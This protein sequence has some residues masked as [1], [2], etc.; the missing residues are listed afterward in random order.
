M[1]NTEYWTLECF[2]RNSIATY[3]RNEEITSVDSFVSPKDKDKVKLKVNLDKVD[4]LRFIMKDIHYFPK[5]IDKFFKN[6]VAFS[7]D[8]CFLREIKQEH[9]KVLPKIIFLDLSVNM[10]EIIE[11]DLF[12]FNP[13][14]Q[15]IDM[16]DNMIKEIDGNVLDD[17]HSLT[18]LKLIGNLCPLENGIGRRKIDKLIKELIVNCKKQIQKFILDEKKNI[19]FNWKKY[20]WIILIFGTSS[21]V[22]LI[23]GIFKIIITVKVSP[24]N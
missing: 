24:E 1:R 5:G 17:L 13:L 23:Y 6:L 14:L 12:K 4:G 21:V 18:T 22:F 15:Y 7:I 3:S 19:K 8:H 11:K 20:F 2:V 10:I 16:I 9:L